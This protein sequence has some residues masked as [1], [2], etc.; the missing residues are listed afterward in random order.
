[1]DLHWT[2]AVYEQPHPLGSDWLMLGHTLRFWPIRC[3]GKSAGGFWN[4]NCSSWVLLCAESGFSKKPSSIRR[5]PILLLQHLRNYQQEIDSFRFWESGNISCCL[6]FPSTKMLLLH[7]KLEVSSSGNL[8]KMRVP[9]SFHK[10]H[11]FLPSWILIMKE[12]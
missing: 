9:N 2:T 8:G 7:T 10:I 4:K 5:S 1:M 6:N 11:S 12:S 3:E